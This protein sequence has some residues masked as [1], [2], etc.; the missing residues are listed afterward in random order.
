MHV[1]LYLCLSRKIK[2]QTIITPFLGVSK[3]PVMEC[4]FT[5]HAGEVYSPMQQERFISTA[6]SST[7]K[8]IIELQQQF[9]TLMN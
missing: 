4:Q 3:N 1:Q 8:R 7:I 2:R 9:R 6:A 5:A